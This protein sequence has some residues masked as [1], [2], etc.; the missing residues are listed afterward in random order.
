MKN[1]V[2]L[3]TLCRSIR[4]DILAS[5]TAAGSGHP[6]SSLS[7]VELMTTLFFGGFYNSN[8]RVIFSKGHAAPLLYAL[9]HQ[10]GK[11]SDKE[12]LTLRQFDS[13]L[14]GHPTPR[15]KYIDVATGSLGQGLSMGAGMALGMKLKNQK[16]K[17][18]ILLGDSEIA[19]GQ[20]WEALEIASY[21]KLNNLVGIL[22]VNRLGQSR[23]T[24]L[25]WDLT[26]YQKRI[27]AFGWSTIIVADGNDLKQVNKAFA[28]IENDKPTMI[29]AKTIKGKGIP[30]VENKEGWHGKVIPTEMLKLNEINKKLETYYAKV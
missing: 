18:F 30:L 14:E 15:F 20:N 16:F 6:T 29:I 2:H 7:A 11:I 8:D 26:T 10:A 1:I 28:D 22:D 9:Y 17:V 5:T 4:H 23:E 19:E 27:E 12:L 24:M 3:L 25:G 21:Y 13:V